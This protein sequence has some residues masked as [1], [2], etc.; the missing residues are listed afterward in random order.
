MTRHSEDNGQGGRLAGRADPGD[1]TRMHLIA[2]CGTPP[3]PDARAGLWNFELLLLLCRRP[4]AVRLGA[5]R[6]RHGLACDVRPRPRLSFSCS[7]PSQVITTSAVTPLFLLLRAFA[8]DHYDKLRKSNDRLRKRTFELFCELSASQARVPE[9]EAALYYLRKYVSKGG[10]LPH[11][12]LQPC[13]FSFPQPADDT[14]S[15]S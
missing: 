4:P 3:E 12:M 7:A 5:Y 13:R 9:L 8:G 14:S 1:A 15:E 10:T 6:V 11:A 2:P